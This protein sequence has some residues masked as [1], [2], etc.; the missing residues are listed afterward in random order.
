M[1]S[2]DAAIVFMIIYDIS[3]N[4]MLWTIDPRLNIANIDPL[5][6]FN[7]IQYELQSFSSITNLIG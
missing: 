2:I 1:I 7:L 4:M 6:T 3:E 5:L